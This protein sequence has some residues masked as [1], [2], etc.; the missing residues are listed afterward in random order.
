MKNLNKTIVSFIAIFL[1]AFDGITQ[2][3]YVN[4]EWES[5]TGVP[6]SFNRSASV[7]D[8]FQNLIVVSNTIHVDGFTQI[9]LAKYDPNGILLW[10]STF[11][12]SGVGDDYGIQ[13][14][15]N[16]TNQIYVV[17]TVY[18]DIDD[19]D[20]C[21][22]KFS[23]AGGLIW[24][25]T[26]DGI[27]NGIDIPADVQLDGMGNVYVAGGSEDTFG[28]SDYCIIKYSPTGIEQWQTYYDYADLHDAATSIAIGSNVVVTG[29]SASSA[30]NWD[31]TT[32]FLDKTTGSITSTQRTTV[33]GV[34]LDN[35]LAVITDIY[36]NTYITGY[37]EIGGNKNIRTLKF[38]SDFNL[39]WNV[40]Y[41]GAY[42]DVANSIDV[43]DSG[44][45][46]IAGYT[47]I[48]PDPSKKD[49][50]TIKY[51]SSGVLQW[52]KRYGQN[53][54]LQTF[55]ADK[56]AIADNQRILVVGTIINGSQ[57]DFLTIGYNPN[58][59]IFFAE[60][61]D[62]DGANDEVSDITI[63]G[64]NFFITGVSDSLGTKT[65]TVVKYSRIEKTM[66]F[67]NNADGKPLYEAN[68]LIVRLDESLILTSAVNDPFIQAG[69]LDKFLTQDAVTE[70]KDA[71]D[72]VCPDC[73][74]TVYKIF[75]GLTSNM[76]TSISRSGDTIRI[77]H[78]WATLLFEFPDGT[79]I[80]GAS[81]E[82]MGIFPSIKYS[83]LNLVGEFHSEP[84]DTL[85]VP[86]Q[87]SLHEDATG[88]W[89]DNH[90][91]VEP[92]WEYET[93]KRHIKVGVFD[94]PVDWDHED[95]DGPDLTETKV[96]GWDF[97]VNESIYTADGAG[98][99]EAHGTAVAG[100]IGA[101]R[102]NDIGVAGIA[103]GSYETEEIL[104]S[105][106]VALYG[107]NIAHHMDGDPYPVLNFIADA[108]IGSATNNLEYEYGYGLHIMNCSWSVSNAPIYGLPNPWYLDTNITLLREAFHYADRNEVTVVASRG[109][110]GLMQ[111]TG[112]YHHAYPA[113][114]DDDWILTIGGTGTDGHYHDMNH[115][116][117]WD[118]KTSRGWE[119]D[120]SAASS[121]SHV[122]SMREDDE[123]NVF[124]GTSAAAPHASGVAGLLMSYLNA[125]DDDYRNL[126]PEDIEYILQMTALDTDLPGV[127][128]L[129]GHGR[130][131]AGAAL[132]QVDKD[133]YILAHFGTDAFPFLLETSLY[134]TGDTVTLSERFENESGVWFLP[135]VPYVVNTWKATTTSTHSIIPGQTIIASWPRHSSSNFFALF[136][137][138][139]V[140]MPRERIELN[141]VSET[142]AVMTAYYYEVFDMSG[143]PVGWW[144]TNSDDF[145]YQFDMTY[146]LLIEDTVAFTEI[147]EGNASNFM[148]VYPNPSD[149][150]QTLVINANQPNEGSIRL[151]D[152]NGKLIL[153]VYE[154]IIQEGQ[155]S[156]SANIE[157]LESGVYFYLLTIDDGTIYHYKIIK[158]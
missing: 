47:G 53:Q 118:F 83:T 64:E 103:G 92:A 77:P 6:N 11:N 132:A 76:T 72:Q 157:H 90:I 44:N 133:D 2:I 151:I 3:D 80:I 149:H 14:V 137:D 73:P 23:S 114:L 7:V 128:S 61:Y 41:N 105:S 129:T 87:R 65:T 119:I 68:D 139:N 124:G 79:D 62:K 82:L 54:N 113:N 33:P 126:A 71:L 43:D 115:A 144:P 63:N 108:V 136:D 106:G 123:Y 28:F 51:N 101:I 24:S 156:Y 145:D 10:E 66:N 142:E 155:N 131:D 45:I 12:G 75:R 89:D 102:N 78:Y 34:G 81:D 104:D 134:S 39:V 100:I 122:W 117:E 17:G 58:G 154:G 36:N 88:F 97:V 94:G 99:S 22:L 25:E 116:L 147:D 18:Q 60:E 70:I 20:F 31:Y 4:K 46:Y 120:V 121:G 125:E 38:D 96:R 111:D 35:A 127:D 130:V 8:N 26:W 55:G 5:S 30:T 112:T 140:I 158:D 95:F 27:A 152:M 52:Q 49:F 91:N 148:D 138:D 146:S 57:K 32:L 98:Y 84:D 13:L 15:I 135:D 50:I 9:H 40:D 74:I 16:S 143:S 93:G 69:T 42:H 67:T 19:M 48:A 150:N 56:I 141:S 86:R 153:N 29:A 107:M 59:Q 109:N 110:S 37:V 85:Y 21:L 1:C